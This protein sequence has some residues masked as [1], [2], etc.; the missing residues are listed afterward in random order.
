[1]TRKQVLKQ[2]DFQKLKPI[3]E[4][5]IDCKNI[6]GVNNRNIKVLEEIYNVKIKIL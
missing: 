2:N 4:N 1:M 5:A 6:C 3:I